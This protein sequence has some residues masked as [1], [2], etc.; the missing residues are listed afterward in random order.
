MAESTEERNRESKKA[1]HLE[2]RQKPEEWTMK[3]HL[4]VT[5]ALIISLSLAS[6]GGS[7]E[8]IKAEGRTAG[9]SAGDEDGTY[10]AQNVNGI[11]PWG[12]GGGTD[13][14]MRPL[15]VLAEKKLGRSIVIRNMTGAAG[16]VAAQYVYDAAADGYHLLMGAENPALYDV[17][18]LSDLT[19]ERFDCIYLIGDETVGI[20]VGKGSP[21]QSFSALIDAAGKAPGTI[22]LATTGTGGMPWEVGAL[23]T[24][25]TGASFNQV[26]YDSDASAKTAVISGECDFTVCKLQS[27]MEDWKAGDLDFLCLFSKE[28]VE[29]MKG[30]PLITAEYPD[31]EPYLP[32]GPFYG[33]FVKEGTDPFVEATLAHAFSEA[34]LDPGYQDMLKNLNVHFLGYTGE[35]ANT[36]LSSWREHTVAALKSSGAI[37]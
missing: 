32:W 1:A 21:Y 30:V 36:Y 10:P 3:K 37:Q 20:T 35:H 2:T 26:P 18:K 31:F 7:S 22:K 12:A 13:S 29:M 19:Y 27:G 34:G 9:A 14:L 23:I 16:T 8:H 25:V 5:L 11:V 17:L 4:A 24:S 28:P 15:S 33:V 6:C